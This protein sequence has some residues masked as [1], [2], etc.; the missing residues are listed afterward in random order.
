MFVSLPYHSEAPF[1][2]SLP[3]PQILDYPIGE[4]LKGGQLKLY[5]A[6][7][8]NIKLGWKGLQEKKHSGLFGPFVSYEEKSCITLSP[9]ANIIKLFTAVSYKFLF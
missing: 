1:R 7:L 8:R 2:C 3:Y 4:N 9:G 6:L 5:Q